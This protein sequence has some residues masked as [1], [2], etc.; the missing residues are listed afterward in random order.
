M[1]VL[2]AALLLLATTVSPRSTL[3]FQVSPLSVDNF[4][5]TAPGNALQAE[6]GDG[7]T[8]LAE[9]TPPDA[10]ESSAGKSMTERMMAKAPQEGQ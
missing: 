5:S 3:A 2:S 1:R 9:P 8:A 10:T 4:R 6:Q 7:S